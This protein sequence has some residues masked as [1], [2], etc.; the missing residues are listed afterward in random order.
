[1]GTVVRDNRVLNREGGNSKPLVRV[2]NHTSA[3]ASALVAA[4]SGIDNCSG[5]IAR[6]NR[7]A[8]VAAII[9][10]DASRDGIVVKGAVMNGNGAA[11]VQDSA[12]KRSATAAGAQTT[13]DR[14]PPEGASGP[15]S[16]PSIA[17]TPPAA[18]AKATV[19]AAPT[20]TTVAITATAATAEATIGASARSAAAT[21]T[22]IAA[23]TVT[24]RAKASTAGIARTGAAATPAGAIRPTSVRIIDATT[25]AAA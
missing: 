15:G 3:L 1:V 12:T 6:K 10:T 13:I 9:S 11:V 25:I 5:A 22:I 18:A 14:I 16:R 4:E 24:R 20:K 19:T 7:A 23:A 8:G 21:A 17:N 2:N